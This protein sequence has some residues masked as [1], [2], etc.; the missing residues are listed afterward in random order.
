LAQTRSAFTFEVTSTATKDQI[1]ALVEKLY[2]VNVT[3]V[4]TIVGHRSLK[5]TGR[6]RLKRSQSKI[7]KAVVTLKPG[8]M[9][10]IFDIQ[11]ATQA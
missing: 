8:Q 3:S 2:N 11:G 6:K 4:N 10:E 9:I 7:K 5:A 1:S